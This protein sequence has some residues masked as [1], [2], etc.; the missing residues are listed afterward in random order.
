MSK[1]FIAGVAT[2]LVVVA[3][4]GAGAYAVVQHQS[5][6]KALQTEQAKTRSMSA[7]LASAQVKQ[8]SA[9]TQTSQTV[10]SSAPVASSASS[11]SRQSPNDIFDN[12]PQKTQL[13]L[14]ITAAWNDGNPYMNTHYGVY[15][16]TANK[17]VIYDYGEGAGG[18][19]DHVARFVDNHDGSFTVAWPHT[20]TDNASA[21]SD[22]T[23]W[24]DHSTIT[25]ADMLARFYATDAEKATVTSVEEELDLSTINKAFDLMPA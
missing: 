6:Q 3:V 20:T 12:L 18:W 21:N 24:Q 8:S 2:A 5:Q 23:T 17:I 10:A 25:K 14:I 16:G 4:G 9:K 19:P 1:G 13:A 15:M 22:N 7:K 11:S